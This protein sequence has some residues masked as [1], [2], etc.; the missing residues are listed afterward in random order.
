MSKKPFVLILID[1]IRHKVGHRC[2]VSQ[3]TNVLCQFCEELLDGKHAGGMIAARLLREAVT[4]ELVAH[5]PEIAT[6]DYQLVVRLF[7]CTKD[8][9][10]YTIDKDTT[11]ELA[12][13]SSMFFA[14]FTKAGP[15]FDWVTTGATSEVPAK[16]CGKCI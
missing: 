3:V 13:I 7:V 9:S 10:H 16:V 4:D 12:R 1:P 15:S 8:I 6:N 11:P 5:H 14:G 2:I